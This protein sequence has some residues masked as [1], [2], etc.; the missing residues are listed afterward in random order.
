[1][2]RKKTS[3]LGTL[4]KGSAISGVGEES[5]SLTPAGSYTGLRIRLGL[6]GTDPSEKAESGSDPRGKKTKFSLMIFSFY[7][8][9]LYKINII[10]ILI[11]YYRFGQ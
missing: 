8:F 6:S 11:L 3:Y 1:M 9:F 7:F 5:I 10:D 4:D 2:L